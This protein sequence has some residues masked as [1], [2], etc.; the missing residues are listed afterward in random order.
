MDR[1]NSIKDDMQ[2]GGPV[3]RLIEYVV[4]FDL[5]DREQVYETGRHF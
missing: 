3:D 5:C 1:Y 4:P 2:S